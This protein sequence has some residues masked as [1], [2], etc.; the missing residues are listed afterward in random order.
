MSDQKLLEAVNRSG[1]P[2]QICLEDYIER[3]SSQHGWKILYSEH[4][5]KN[6]NDG[7]SGF[8]DIVLENKC[9]Y[10]VLIVEAKR[11]LNSSW[12]FLVTDSKQMSRRHAKSWF[13]RYKDNKFTYFGWQD[14]SLEPSTVESQFCVVDGQDPKSRPMVERIAADVISSLEG[15]ANEEKMLALENKLI[16]KTYLSVIVTTATLKVCQFDPRNVSI[17][18]GQTPD[19]IFQEVPYLRF[20]KQLNSNQTTIIEGYKKDNHGQIDYAKENTVFI[21]NAKYFPSFLE[22]FEVD[23]SYLENYI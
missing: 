15:F 4:S 11:V 1:F 10:S 7:C 6:Q 13:T 3:T 19:G 22:A 5:W 9:K 23:R 8:I 12:I 20:R 18:D 14:I 16:F 17:E 21:V 2:L